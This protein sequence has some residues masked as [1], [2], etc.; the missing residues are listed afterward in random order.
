MRT[1]QP[2]AKPAAKREHLTTMN[3][4][5]VWRL[6]DWSEHTGGEACG[7]ADLADLGSDQ[8]ARAV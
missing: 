6:C 8:E 1:A 7:S 3:S 4:Y 5:D 2:K